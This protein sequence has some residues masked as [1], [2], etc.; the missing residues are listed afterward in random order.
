LYPKVASL[1][2]EA[3]GKIT[4][5]KTAVFSGQIEP[6]LYF[7]RIGVYIKVLFLRKRDFIAVLNI[8]AALVDEFGNLSDML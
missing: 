6:K 7:S 8:L 3:D 5:N 4:W 2:Q 1:S